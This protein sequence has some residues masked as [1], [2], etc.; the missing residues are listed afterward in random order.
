MLQSPKGIRQRPPP[1]ASPCVVRL[2]T[3]SG[4]VVSIATPRAISLESFRPIDRVTKL[5]RRVEHTTKA[6]RARPCVAIKHRPSKLQRPSSA[7]R[8]HAAACAKRG[9]KPS[10]S[11]LVSSRELACLP[12]LGA[13]FSF[14]GLLDFSL[15][16]VSDVLDEATPLA[17]RRTTGGTP[18]D[19]PVR[20]SC[21]TPPGAPTRAG[22]GRAAG[23]SPARQR[24][25]QCPTLQC[26]SESE[27]ERGGV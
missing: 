15:D 9:A 19:Q 5:E 17:P 23:E 22:G 4:P 12:D 24:R 21:T 2:P 14:E 11:T 18:T 3:E 13:G 8:P 6:V 20:A 16:C 27:G 25:L 10:A 26:E 7:P 1:S